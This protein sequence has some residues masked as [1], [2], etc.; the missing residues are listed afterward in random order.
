[1]R[2]VTS[3]GVVKDV[4]GIARVTEQVTGRPLF[5]GALQDV[6]ESKVAEEALNKARS[7]LAPMARV[8]TLGALTASIAHEVNQPLGAVVNN[9]SACLR[10]LR[11][12][13]LEEARQSAARVIADGHRASEIIQRIRQLATKS[14]PRKDRLD[15]NG[16]VGNVEPLVRA[17]L[18]RH[19]VALT[20]DLAPGLP[21]VIG[22]RVQLQQ[23]LLNLMM[24]GIEAMAPVRDRPRE[25]LIQSRPH[26]EDQVLVAVQ[27][28]GVGIDPNDLDQLFSAFFTT[29]PAGM[30]IGLSI[31]RS[32][33]DAHGGRLWATPNAGYGATFHFALP[34]S[35]S[36][37]PQAAQSQGA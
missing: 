28:S 29:K 17:E 25:L 35:G 12:Q 5:I 4:R 27:D 3:R 15:V 30:G 20:L 26:A 22:D 6:T 2:I 16:V 14:P 34:G 33:V 19:E 1:F 18:R 36:R 21:P 37:S 24:N 31:C 10:W 9:A 11:A 32:I 13:N 23:V 7:E 8:T